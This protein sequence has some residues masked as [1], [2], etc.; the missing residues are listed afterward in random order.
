MCVDLFCTYTV[1]ELHV[2]LFQDVESH[3]RDV[4]DETNAQ[5]A[6]HFKVMKKIDEDYMYMKVSYRIIFQ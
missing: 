2:Q 3:L 1:I 5:G 4:K 6:Q